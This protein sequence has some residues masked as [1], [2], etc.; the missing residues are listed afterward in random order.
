[1]L[2]LTK[3]IT[4]LFL[5][6][7][8]LSASLAHALANG[9]LPKKIQL[10]YDVKRNGKLFARVKESFT[11][12]GKQYRVDSTTKG[13]G[14]YALYG[15]RKLSSVGEVTKDG[16]KPK[17]FELRQGNS[18]S[19]TLIADFDWAK[20][21]LAMQVKGE[22]KTEPLETGTQDLSSYVYQFMYNPPASDDVNV[23]LTTGKNLNHYQYKVLDRGL[24][25]QA[26][27]TNYNTLHIANEPAAGDD[28][29]QLWL[30][31]DQYYLPVRYSIVDENN[32]NLEQTLT[33]FHVE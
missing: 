17:R 6:I 18:A 22:T 10:E 28:K 26:A 1:M 20:S 24:K 8:L 29:K 13:V 33:K 11:Q 32:V 31:E 15:A 21:T 30:A 2:K 23:T 14:I 12:D 9:V 3:L 5:C 4:F 27:K 25:L 16:L 19:K 7:F